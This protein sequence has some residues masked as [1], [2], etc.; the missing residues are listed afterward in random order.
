VF[1]ED[2]I[3]GINW[4]DCQPAP[5]EVRIYDTFLMGISIIFAI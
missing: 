3:I 5:E 4:M 2:G 1:D